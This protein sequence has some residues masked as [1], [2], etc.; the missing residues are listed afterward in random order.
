V[1]KVESG[2]RAANLSV[3]YGNFVKQGDAYT[4]EGVAVHTNSTK[5]APIE[6]LWNSADPDDRT[7]AMNRLELVAIR[8]PLRVQLLNALAGGKSVELATYAKALDLSLPQVNYHC[9][10]LVEADAVELQNG[11]ARITES[12]KELHRFA[13]RPDRRRKADR[14][15]GDRRDRR[16][17]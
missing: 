2:R 6:P 14:R 9:E 12:G 4:A 3:D 1:L 11:S 8:H 7:G 10:G 16:R 13:Q 5:V 17:G 15:R